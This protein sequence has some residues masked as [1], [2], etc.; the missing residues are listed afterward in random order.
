M[1]SDAEKVVV[2]VVEGAT[3]EYSDHTEWP[4]R[5]F[6]DEQAANVFCERVSARARELQQQYKSRYNIPE[7]ANELDPDMYIDYTGVNYRVYPIDTYCCGAIAARLSP[8][9]TRKLVEYERLQERCERL[10][11]AINEA[12]NILGSGE[13]RRPDCPGCEYE[14]TVAVKELRDAIDS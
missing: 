4:V 2:W 12:L 1:S 7:G 11:E 10:E 9:T 13:C 14:R 5:A 3:G 8:E 6:T